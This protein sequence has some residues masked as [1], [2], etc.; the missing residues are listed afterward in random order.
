MEKDLR[1]LNSTNSIV[2]QALS[3]T[4]EFVTPEESLLPS[5]FEF[6]NYRLYLK[7]YFDFK[8]Q[9]DPR[10]TLAKLATQMGFSSHAGLAMIMSGQREL[11]SPYIEKFCNLVNFKIKERLYFEALLRGAEMSPQKRKKF[12]R[13]IEVL[14]DEWLPPKDCGNARLI[15]YSVTHQILSLYKRPCTREEIKRQFKYR[16]QDFVLDEILLSMQ[17][18]NVV[19]KENDRFRLLK[20]VL[21]IENNAPAGSGKEMHLDFMELAKQSLMKEEPSQREFQ[22][23]LV[24]IDSKRLVEMKKRIKSLVVQILEEYEDNQNS[25]T[26]VQFHFNL[27]ECTKKLTTEESDDSTSV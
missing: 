17:K 12:I 13:S 24:T 5:V 20:D 25:D 22:T 8:K 23:Y 19:E 3:E 6:Q 15:D 11:R 10:F 1:D 27:F 16:I 18:S 21:V 14:T 7:A 2:S 26:S 4:A 9:I